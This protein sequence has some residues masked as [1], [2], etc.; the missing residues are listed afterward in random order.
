MLM[1]LM[2]DDVCVDVWNLVGLPSKKLL[3]IPK[4]CYEGGVMFGDECNF[5]SNGDAL[6][7]TSLTSTLVLMASVSC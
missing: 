2:R 7:F 5:N 3:E 4:K 6:C 1:R